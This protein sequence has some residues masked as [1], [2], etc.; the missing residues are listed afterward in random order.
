MA[1]MAGEILAGDTAKNDYS[2]SFEML[3]MNKGY[4]RQIQVMNMTYIDR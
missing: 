2:L 1:A 3:K 4:H